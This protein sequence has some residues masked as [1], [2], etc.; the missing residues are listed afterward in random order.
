MIKQK[1]KKCARK[2]L[3]YF[4]FLIYQIQFLLISSFWIN[5]YFIEQE[6]T[7]T[8]DELDGIKKTKNRFPQDF[9]IFLSFNE[10]QKKIENKSET[11]TEN[12]T[13]FGTK[14][15]SKAIARAPKIS[16][17]RVN[18]SRN[19]KKSK[20]S[21]SSD[22][23]NGNVTPISQDSQKIDEKKEN[24]ISTSTEKIEALISVTNGS[25]DVSSNE[26]PLPS[27]EEEVILSKQL[28][29][30][31][32]QLNSNNFF[33][34][35][36]QNDLSTSI[37][38]SQSSSPLSSN[39]P[40]PRQSNNNTSSTSP[41][42]KISSV[43]SPRQANNLPSPLNNILPSSS[44]PFYKTSN[45]PSP[46]QSNNNTPSTSP[47]SNSSSFPSNFTSSPIL[48]CGS[49][50]KPI[51]SSYIRTEKESFHSSCYVCSVCQVKTKQ[52]KK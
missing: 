30:L 47:S 24:E 19:S 12:K 5:T 35:S 9:K 4:Y 15:R 46:P 41:S 40:S 50:Q 10:T 25:S 23:S 32:E 36:E 18:F 2:I 37:L 31:E 26:N 22:T 51:V 52:N 14:T 29:E 48:I 39:D 13:E 34:V 16:S 27:E 20:D 3:F 28:R 42:S 44:S 21:P 8:L 17:Q 49:C 45:T 1:K 7:L 33:S 11:S 6:L 38:K 43:P